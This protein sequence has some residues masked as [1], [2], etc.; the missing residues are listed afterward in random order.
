MGEATVVF[1]PGA[2]EITEVVEPEIDR[3][4]IIA[5]QEVLLQRCRAFIEEVK[6]RV[7]SLPPDLRFDACELLR[8]AC[9]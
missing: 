4:E 7:D 5:Q 6:R 9:P 1:F 2:N 3:D 8:E